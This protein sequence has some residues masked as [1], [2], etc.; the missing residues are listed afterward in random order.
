[1]GDEEV[2]EHSPLLNDVAS[3]GYVVIAHKSA[4]IEG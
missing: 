3:Q 2:W 1:M 4:G